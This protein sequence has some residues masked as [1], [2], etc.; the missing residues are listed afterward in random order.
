M[1]YSAKAKNLYKTGW[2]ESLNTYT[3]FGKLIVGYYNTDED[4]RNEY[5]KILKKLPRDD[6]VKSHILAC[7]MAA[8]IKNNPEDYGDFGEHFIAF[9]RENSFLN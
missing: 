2:M 6:E 8:D 4:A 3:D 1:F 5:F 7:Y 9:Y